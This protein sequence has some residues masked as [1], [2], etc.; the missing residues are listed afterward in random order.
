MVNA[1][2]GR[3]WIDTVHDKL[4]Y[5]HTGLCGLFREMLEKAGFFD[6]VEDHT[7]AIYEDL[8]IAVRKQGLNNAQSRTSSGDS[9]INYFTLKLLRSVIRTYERTNLRGQ[10]AQQESDR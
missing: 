8:I 9:T 2:T 4:V 5:G 3:F 1:A 6:L 10:E 7:Q